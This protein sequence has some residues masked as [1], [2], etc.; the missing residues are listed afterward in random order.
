VPKF[1]LR[2]LYGPMAALAFLALGA[3][4]EVAPA[5]EPAAVTPTAS[6]P[7]EPAAA[8]PPPA[9]LNWQLVAPATYE[10]GPAG[11]SK[12]FLSE[13]GSANVVYS[14]TA[15]KAGETVVAN[16]DATGDVDK[17]L[18]VVLIRHCN[19]ENGEEAASEG[20]KLTGQPQSLVV[21]RTF[22]KDF[23]CVRLSFLSGDGS[24]LQASISNVVVRKE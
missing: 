20:F 12:L 8:V 10:P 23:G 19:P 3:C 6:A 15:V 2:I 24:P 17:I 13:K 9:V 18:R 16:F 14:E 5:V 11:A 22:E 1:Q 7:A 21:R 4:D